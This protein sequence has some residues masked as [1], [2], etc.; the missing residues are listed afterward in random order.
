[1]IPCM[2]MAVAMTTL[3]QYYSN[4]QLKQEGCEL[5]LQLEQQL[6]IIIIIFYLII[7]TTELIAQSIFRNGKMSLSKSYS[8]G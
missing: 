2:C 1:M 5:Y 4:H 8:T 3:H 7:T 6:I